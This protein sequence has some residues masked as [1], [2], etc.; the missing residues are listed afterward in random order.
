MCLAKNVSHFEIETK[1]LDVGLEIEHV[2]KN[3]TVHIVRIVF[4]LHCTAGSW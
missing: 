3:Q 1:T 4:H 2:F